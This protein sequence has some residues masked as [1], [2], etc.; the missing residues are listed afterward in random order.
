MVRERVVKDHLDFSQFNGAGDAGREQ[1]LELCKGVL[2]P[3]HVPEDIALRV[4]VAPYPFVQAH[5]ACS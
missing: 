1:P 5:S 4:D 3:R 2:Y